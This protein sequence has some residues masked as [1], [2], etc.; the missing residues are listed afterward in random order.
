MA[1]IERR[2]VGGKFEYRAR[3]RDENGKSRRSRWFGRKFDAERHRATVEAD[4]HRGAYVDQSNATTV[5]EFARAWIEARPYRPLSVKN[6]SVFIR[7]R[8]E[9]DPLGARPLVKVRPSE[10]Q[11][12]ATRQAN[13]DGTDGRSD[14]GHGIGPQTLRIQTGY[15]RSIFSSAVLDGLIARNPVQPANRLSLPKMDQPKLVPL[16]VEQV[17]TLAE[18]MPPHM[19]AMVITQAGLGLR[20]GELIALRAQDVNFLRREVRIEH[21]LELN[22]LRRVPPK[23]PR[24]RRTVPLPAVVANSLAQHMAAFPPADDGLLFYPVHAPTVRKKAGPGIGHNDLATAIRRAVKRAG[25]PDGTSSH[26]L[27]HHYASVLLHAGESVHAVAE[28]LGHTD[29]KLVLETYGHCMPDSEDR[30]RQA[31]DAAWSA[32]AAALREAPSSG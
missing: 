24:S 30:T 8:L 18:E 25:L 10:I 12:W 2:T 28:R 3:W 16:T 21:Q 27:R 15:L 14:R 22:T 32:P 7:N 31:V 26:D 20:M 11:N 23:T 6:M 29:A 5:A 17:R 1:S 13:Q 4:L 19:R 9:K